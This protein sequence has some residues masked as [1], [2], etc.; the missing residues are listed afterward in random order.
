VTQDLG[1]NSD[2]EVKARLVIHILDVKHWIK[3]GSLGFEQL[4]EAM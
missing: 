1:E 4:T 3:Q 2:M